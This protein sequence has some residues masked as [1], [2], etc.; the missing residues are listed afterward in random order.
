MRFMVYFK[1]EKDKRFAPM[2][3]VSGELFNRLAYA[4]VY[5]GSMLDAVK[6]WIDENKKRAPECKLQ[7][8]IAGTAKIIYQ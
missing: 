6:G 1:G 5:G 7:I 2:D 3:I 8:R 4:P